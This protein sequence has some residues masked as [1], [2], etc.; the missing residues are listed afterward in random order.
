MSLFY[1]YETVFYTFVQQ[2]ELQKHP[3]PVKLEQIEF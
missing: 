3:S 1:I 2:N